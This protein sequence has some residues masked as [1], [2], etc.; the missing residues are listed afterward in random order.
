M[1]NKS[2]EFAN[3]YYENLLLGYTYDITLRDIFS[4]Y[5]GQPFMSVNTV[6]EVDVD[7]RVIFI[8]HVDKIYSGTSRNG[9]KYLKL[10][11]SDEAGI[12]DVM[13]FNKKM[14]SCIVANN[15]ELIKKQDIVIVKGVKKD[16]VVFADTIG[17]QMNRVYTK[18]TELK[19]L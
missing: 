12:M 4:A 13:I 17:A 3:W 11:V 10:S 15:N 5:E 1:N 18:L 19:N 9:N 8:G 7:T 16:G 14:E 6:K 2:Q